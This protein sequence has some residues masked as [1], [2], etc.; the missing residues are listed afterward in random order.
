MINY[1]PGYQPR[2]RTESEIEADLD[3]RFSCSSG[4]PRTIDPA[5]ASP[6]PDGIPEKVSLSIGKR[7]DR[8]HLNK[9]VET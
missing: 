8:K 2:R 6:P 9:R 5:L 7:T 3:S 1:P 4:P